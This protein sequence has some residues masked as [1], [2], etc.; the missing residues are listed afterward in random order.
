MAEN[1]SVENQEMA[2]ASQSE[3]AEATLAHE[4]A[5][6]WATQRDHAAVVKRTREELKSDIRG[7]ND[8]PAKPFRLSLSLSLRRRSRW[9]RSR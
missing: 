9:C 8:F 2:R 4:I 1:Q 3:A 7:G 6:P 5:V